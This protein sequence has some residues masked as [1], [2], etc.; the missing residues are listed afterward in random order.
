LFKVVKDESFNKTIRM[1]ESLIKQL[2]KVAYENDISFNK[3]IV[4]C[5]KYALDNMKMDEKDK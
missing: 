2:E 5:C 4:Q 1:P 3:L